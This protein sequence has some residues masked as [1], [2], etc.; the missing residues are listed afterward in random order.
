MNPLDRETKMRILSHAF[1]VELILDVIDEMAN[2]SATLKSFKPYKSHF[3]ELKHG[4]KLIGKRFPQ[5]QILPGLEKFTPVQI[6]FLSMARVR[7]YNSFRCITFN[8]CIAF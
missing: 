5:Y 1:S 8:F 7:N 2:A 3:D 4:N 6:A